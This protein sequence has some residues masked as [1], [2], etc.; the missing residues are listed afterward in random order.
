MPGFPCYQ[1]PR[2]YAAKSGK[3]RGMSVGIVTSGTLPF[4][5]LNTQPALFRKVASRVQD[6]VWS[7]FGEDA[8]RALRSPNITINETRRRVAICEKWIR[9]MRGDLNYTWEKALDMMGL[10]LRADLD[11]KHFTPPKA[12]EA[13]VVPGRERPMVADMEDR[14]FEQPPETATKE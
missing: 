11:G 8:R 12:D 2:Q 5:D 10:A 14:T 6:V 13:W 7:S 3:L 4:L 1:H 9:I